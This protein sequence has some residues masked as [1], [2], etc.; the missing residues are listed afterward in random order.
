[1]RV[2]KIAGAQLVLNSWFLV[3]IVLFS[4][5]GMSVKILIVFSAILWHELAHAAV[6]RAL[7]F[8]V[9]EIELLPFGG[10]ARIERLGE[11][12]AKNEMM[13]AAAGPVASMVLAAASYLGVSYKLGMEELLLFFYN[14]NIMLAVFN[15]APGLPLDGGRMLRAWLALSLGYGRA[16]W[17]VV[18]LSK[19]ISLLLI[20]VVIH[21]YIQFSTINL[22]FIVAA[23]ILYVASKAESRMAGFRTMRILANKKAELKA[24]GLMPAS[25]F[26][27]IA[28][29]PVKELICLLE[30]DK[31]YVI[32]VVDE[33]L[34]IRGSLTETELWEALPSQG[35]YAE[36]GEFL[37]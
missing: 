19:C 17:I 36:I 34:R 18:R 25:H 20:L 30:P 12:G 11:V 7:G 14:I 37:Q 6:A 9:R 24:R 1:M 5:A 21:N 32:L 31:Y 15:L 2:C 8:K 26:A 23:T 29:T 10:V 4:L 16:T 13:I 33:A 3:L 35:M 22:T 27:I 28:T